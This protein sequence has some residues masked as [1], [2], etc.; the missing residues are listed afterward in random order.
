VNDP[1]EGLEL[2]RMSG[3]PARHRHSLQ[4]EINRALYMDEAT[5]EPSSGFAPLKAAIDAV[6]KKVAGC[7]QV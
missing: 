5:R 3:E 4:I 2:I 6:V 7:V 1:Y